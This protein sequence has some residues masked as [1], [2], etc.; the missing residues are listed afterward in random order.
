MKP[1]EQRNGELPAVEGS[2]G[3]RGLH[4]V[5]N[6]G[7]QHLTVAYGAYQLPH[8]VERGEIGDHQNGKAP[9]VAEQVPPEVGLRAAL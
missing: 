5:S 2:A 1:H 3:Q 4:A 8:D 7:P 9:Q 6:R